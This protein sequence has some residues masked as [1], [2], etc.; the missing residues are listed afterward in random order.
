M[1][2]VVEVHT[3]VVNRSPS[4]DTLCRD[5]AASNLFCGLDV[6]VDFA[7]AWSV[8]CVLSLVLHRLLVAGFGA[9]FD[10]IQTSE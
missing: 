5:M 3:V 7:F 8:G 1:Q 2:M 6:V 10:A 9:P 4:L